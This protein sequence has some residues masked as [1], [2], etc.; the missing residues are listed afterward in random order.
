MHK[1][2]LFLILLVLPVCAQQWGDPSDGKINYSYIYAPGMSSTETQ[3]A[4]YCPDFITATNERVTCTRGIETVQACVQCCTFAEVNLKSNQETSKLL[5]RAGNLIIPVCAYWYAHY[6][7]SQKYSS[8]CSTIFLPSAITYALW[9]QINFAVFSL[10]N[11]KNGVHVQQL[12]KNTHSVATHWINPFK[13]NIAQDID[14]AIC[15]TKIDEAIA[16]ESDKPKRIILYGVSRGSATVF[17]T[18]A[19]HY[20]EQIAAIVCEGVFDTVNNI[21]VYGNVFTKLKIGLLKYSKLTNFKTE[22][23]SPITSV[24]H[25]PKNV[26]IALITSVIDE[27]VPHQCTLNLYK[28]L[29]EL[30]YTKVHILILK[31][32]KHDVYPTGSEKEIY[33]AFIHAF[34]KQYNLPHIEKFAA[35]GEKIFSLSRPEI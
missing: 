27:V 12:S 15:K 16:Q 23:I 20:S 1:K 6:N 34:Y 7:L 28:K 22:G 35:E 14:V 18:C 3:L 8:I 17:S 5:S 19:R 26:P 21:L 11:Q 31:T 24:S 9:H 32:S 2:I 13:I 33:Q 25:M 29:R 10:K 4:R 30:G